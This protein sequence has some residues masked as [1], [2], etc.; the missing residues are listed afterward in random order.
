[1]PVLD[2]IEVVSNEMSF[3]D[4]QEYMCT[5]GKK[6][7]PSKENNGETVSFKKIKQPN[8]PKT[9]QKKLTAGNF[10]PP[11]NDDECPIH[12]GHVWSKCFDNPNGKNYKPRGQDE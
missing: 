10:H 6:K 5:S 8:K 3:A 9:P 12:G 7:T 1:M 4:A 2:I 11:I